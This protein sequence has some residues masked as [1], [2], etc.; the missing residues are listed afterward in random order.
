MTMIELMATTSVLKK[1]KQNNSASRR[2][3]G[4]LDRWK[5]ADPDND[6]P[7]SA[8]EIDRM[9]VFLRD[10]AL[11]VY[12][13][14]FPEERSS[15]DLEEEERRRA[16]RAELAE[17]Q[18]QLQEAAI[19]RAALEDYAAGLGDAYNWD[20]DGVILEELQYQL[21]AEDDWAIWESSRMRWWPGRLMQSLWADP[22]FVLNGT[23]IIRVHAEADLLCD[24]PKNLQTQRLLEELNRES[25]F[26]AHVWYPD[27]GKIKLRCN[28]Y[29]E[30]KRTKWLIGFFRVIVALQATE[31]HESASRLAQ[32]FKARPDSSPHPT[33]G[34]RQKSHA[35]L[36]CGLKPM[37]QARSAMV[38]EMEHAMASKTVAH[39]GKYALLASGGRSA[40]VRLELPRG[41]A[42]PF[43]LVYASTDWKH[44]WLGE[45][46][47]VVLQIPSLPDQSFADS[48][49]INGLNIAEA[50]E[51]SKCEGWGAWCADPLRDGGLAF[52]CFV[53]ADMYC[54]GL[55][56]SLTMYMSNRVQWLAAHL[57]PADANARLQ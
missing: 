10:H 27:A 46:L 39:R 14:L 12:L 36:H 4:V 29:F 31:A 40:R 54:P 16:E 38:E 19:R 47:R 52:S 7:L 35:V 56:N 22:A 49:F 26:S 42:I 6:R 30:P 53:P 15:I 51:L 28:S 8:E 11:G 44:P 37:M 55:L 43:A 5:T 50:T 34:S 33:S 13:D 21:G 24:V 9:K 3:I 2:E 48:A 17:K 41:C 1:W 23:P 45:G 32:R 20:W 57:R 18:F 25:T